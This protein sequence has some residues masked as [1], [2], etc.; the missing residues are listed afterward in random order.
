MM[1]VQYTAQM[2][3]ALA[4]STDG[5]HFAECAIMC[6]LPSTSN[7]NIAGLGSASVVELDVTDPEDSALVR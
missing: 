7:E 5:A 2:G 3:E 4:L 6:N 1:F